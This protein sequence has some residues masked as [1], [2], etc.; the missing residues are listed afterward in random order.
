MPRRFNEAL[1]IQMGACNPSGIAH[2][3]VA[4]CQE[5]RDE[6]CTPSEDAAVRLMVH[7]LAFICKV[8]EIDDGFDVYRKLTEECRA[9]DK[10]EA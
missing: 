6:G 3:I 8:A 5:A 10:V 4:A 1:F 2:A 9:K 7:Q